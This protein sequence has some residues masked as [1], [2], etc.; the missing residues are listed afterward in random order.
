[1]ELADRAK[2]A[3]L[4]DADIE[5]NAQRLVCRPA[6]KNVACGLHHPL[7]LDHPPAL[8]AV[9]GKLFR[10]PLEDRALRLLDLQEERLAVA[11]QE[12]PDNADRAD[13]ADP[14]RLEGDV[15]QLIPVEKNRPVGGE[16][17]AVEREAA[18]KVDPASDRL[19]AEVEDRRRLVGDPGLAAG[20]EVRKVVVPVETAAL[21][22]ADHGQE[23]APQRRAL[24]ALE[25]ILEIDPA[26]PDFQWRKAHERKH[27]LAISG[28][29][30]R[31]EAARP[32]AR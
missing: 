7:P 22:V 28:H 30:A 31:S 19:R 14:D 4:Q 18:G 12:Q 24:D 11:A 8:R 9:V 26:V 29:R 32:L 23:A 16:G 5:P 1:G 25:L 17:A 20:H 15:L 27:V 21:S 13:R 2:P 3:V 10:E 6:E